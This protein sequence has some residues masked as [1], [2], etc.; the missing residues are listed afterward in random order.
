MKS[1]EYIQ[2]SP[3]SSRRQRRVLEHLGDVY[4]KLGNKTES[5][6][7]WRDALEKDPKNT[8]LE[9][10]SGIYEKTL[11]DVVLFI[12]LFGGCGTVGVNQMSR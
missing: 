3:E 11:C 2:K 4:F 12:F 5:A 6:R 8:Q 10:K 7:Y 1:A 9:Q